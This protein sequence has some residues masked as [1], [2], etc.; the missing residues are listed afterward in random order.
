M[1]ENAF[2]CTCIWL[3]G[4]ANSYRLVH[5]S[6]I[7]ISNWFELTTCF[8]TFYCDPYFLLSQIRI[9]YTSCYTCNDTMYTLWLYCN[10]N[11]VVTCVCSI[12]ED[13]SI[14]FLVACNIYLTNCY[15]KI[16]AVW[17]VYMMNALQEYM[18]NVICC[19][20]NKQGRCVT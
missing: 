11:Q 13:M 19:H 6:Y 8:L 16:A 7:A 12:Y 9:F 14:Q 17:W 20:S 1:L 15:L 2:I 4:W 5:Y 18:W 10:T 3:H